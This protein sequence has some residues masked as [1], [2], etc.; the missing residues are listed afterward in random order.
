MS[1]LAA[2]SPLCM[3]SAVGCFAAVS[4]CAQIANSFQPPDE[5]ESV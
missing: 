1:T 2:L 5:Q 3:A 4:A